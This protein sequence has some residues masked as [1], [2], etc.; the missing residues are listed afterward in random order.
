MIVHH[1]SFIVLGITGMI[2]TIAYRWYDLEFC[3][4]VLKQNGTYAKQF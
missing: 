3:L 4:Q 2:D 1:G